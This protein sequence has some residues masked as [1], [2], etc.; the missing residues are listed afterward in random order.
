MPSGAVSDG[1]EQPPGVVH[2]VGVGWGDRFPGVA[3][4][5]GCRNTE[6]PQQ[7][8]LAVGAVVGQC[9][10]GPLA[11]DQHAA[12]GVAQAFTAVS[13]ALACA[14]PHV[15]LGILGLNAIAEPVGTSR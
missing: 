14:R 10:A 8:V 6:R 1:M 9:L 13:F 11:G 5:V 15:R 4:R 2:V 3:G 12:P 7:P